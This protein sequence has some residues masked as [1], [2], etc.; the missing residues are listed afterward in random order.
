MNQKEKKI[1]K[2]VTP[3]IEEAGYKVLGVKIRFKRE[4]KAIIITIDKEEGVTIGNC[5]EISRLISPI[6]EE[7]DPIE[8]RY[9]IIVSSPGKDA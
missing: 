9:S 6:I 8:E 2:I 4:R 7:K 3:I 5:E 1:K